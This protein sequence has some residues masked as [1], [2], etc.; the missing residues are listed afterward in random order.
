MSAP[1]ITCLFYSDATV[2]RLLQSPGGT[3][4]VGDLIIEVANAPTLAYTL[5]LET[6]SNH[7]GIVGING[8]MSLADLAVE[9]DSLPC[10]AVLAPGAAVGVS[11]L[12]TALHNLADKSRDFPKITLLVPTTDAASLGASLG[13]ANRFAVAWDATALPSKDLVDFAKWLQDEQFNDDG[14]FDGV[15]SYTPGLLDGT[16]ATHVQKL[17]RILN[18]FADKNPVIQRDVVIASN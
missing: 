5:G 10:P 13:V 4:L 9:S 12:R 6:P 17:G 2:A 11:A 16:A 3:D 14:S 1:E 8:S 15:Y 7:P 18:K